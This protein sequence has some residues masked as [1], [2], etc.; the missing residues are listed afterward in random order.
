MTLLIEKPAHF[1]FEQCLTFLQR[2]DQELLHSVENG[3]LYKAVMIGK[4]KV[5]F[6]IY[7][8]ADTLQVEFLLGEKSPKNKDYVRQ[9]IKHMFDLKRDLSPFYRLAQSDSILQPLIEKYAGYRIIG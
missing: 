9:Y 8:Q 3:A 6:R 5:L 4:E 2:S 1:S 7:K